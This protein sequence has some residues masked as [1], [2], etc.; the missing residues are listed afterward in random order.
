[1]ELYVRYAPP[2]RIRAAAALIHNVW[3]FDDDDEDDDDDDGGC[4]GVALDDGDGEPG[5]DVDDGEV[6]DA[7]D[8]DE[9]FA[10]CP[11]EVLICR[12]NSN[13]GITFD[14]TPTLSLTSSLLSI[15]NLSKNIKLFR[16]YS[17]FD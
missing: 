11:A 5:A 13:V 7:E 15:Y 9:P 14:F 17:N 1:M 8:L 6:D 2:P 4:V 12:F 16:L 10:F 3:L